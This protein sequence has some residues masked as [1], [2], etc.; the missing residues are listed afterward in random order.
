MSINEEWKNFESGQ[1][2]LLSGMLAMPAIKSLPSKDPLALLK[3]NLVIHIVWAIV[4]SI[5]YII[6][7]IL[8][9]VWQLILCFGI[10]FLFTCWSIIAAILLHRKINSAIPGR[11]TLGEMEHYYSSIRKWMRVQEK[12]WLFIYPVSIIGGCMIGAVIASGKPV[13]EVIQNQAVIIAT[14][15]AVVVLVPFCS[16]LAKVMNRKSFGNYAEQLKNNIRALKE[17]NTLA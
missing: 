10:V 11:N 17:D 1:D 15:I 2:E 4:I 14:V 13:E 5:I 12:V 3:K 6:V 9:P 8:F 16:Y 7:C